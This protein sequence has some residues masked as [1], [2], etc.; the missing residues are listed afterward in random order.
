MEEFIYKYSDVPKKF[1]EDFFSFTNENY[2][3]DDFSINIENV[4]CQ[5]N[6]RKDNL[7]ILLINNFDE[8]YDYDIE[9]IKIKHLNGATRKD[10][11][12]ITPRNYII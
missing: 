6:V 10:Q 11:I 5:L 3:D 1:V 8:N 12:M 4:A 7:K 9:I 2:N